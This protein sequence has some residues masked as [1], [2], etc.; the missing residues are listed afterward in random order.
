ML[1]DCYIPPT[2]LVYAH[3]LYGR[4]IETFVVTSSDKI[5]RSAGSLITVIDRFT[6]SKQ[7]GGLLIVEVGTYALPIKTINRR[8]RR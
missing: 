4:N 6:R 8:E 7:E 3:F 2:C 1:F 5:L